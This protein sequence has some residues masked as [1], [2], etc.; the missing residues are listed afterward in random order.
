MRYLAGVGFPLLFQAAFTYVMMR[1]G[2]GGGSFVGLGAMVLGV[3]GIPLT[4]ILNIAL[5]STQSA[6]SGNTPAGRLILITLV[7]PL[8]QLALLIAV[9]VFRL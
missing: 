6:R 4:A 5:L 9:S 1:A 2:T 8:L 3:I 7:L